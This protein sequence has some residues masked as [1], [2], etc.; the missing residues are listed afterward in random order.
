MKNS[1]SAGITGNALN[2]YA[3]ASELKSDGFRENNNTNRTNI[4]INS[5]Y[6]VS[7]RSNVQ[8]L[9]RVTKMKAFIPSSL[10][11]TTFLQTP[12][13]AA[14]NWQNI[15]GFENYT[16]GQFGLSYNHFTKSDEKISIATFGSF[17]NAEELRPFNLLEESSNFM[18]WRGYIQKVVETQNTRIA[19]TSGLEF[20]R[21]K[22]N[23][24]TLSNINTQLLSDN[25]EKRQY[26]NLFFQMESNFQETYYV[27]VGLNGNLTRFYYSDRF[28]ENGD[29]S[30][31]HSYKPVFSP[32][33]GMNIVLSRKF[34]IYG[35]VSH[36]F[37]TPTFEETLLPQGEINTG[38]KPESGLNTEV[39]F[40]SS[41]WGKIQFSTSYYRIY[42]KNLLVARRTGEDAYIGVNA[43]SSI[44]PGLETELKWRITSPFY[45]PSVSILGNATVSN[46]HFTD[47]VDLGVNYSGNNLPG[48]S[49]LTGLGMLNL[50]PSK[51]FD[52]IFWYRYT[53]EMPVNDAN[54]DFSESFGITNAEIN[55]R[56]K[57]NKFKFEVK[58]G[59]QNLFD[60]NYAG[61]LAVNAPSFG[62]G[63]PRYYY[64]G[65]PRNYYVTVLIGLE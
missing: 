3:L 34:S 8:L 7:E 45:Y 19:F 48:T 23:W 62:G 15:K 43:G 25:V 50:S 54:S 10:D 39:G 17:R 1:L 20:F 26:E 22:Y 6:T 11:K 58:A 47:F 32:R 16:N 33:L 56:G 37:S 18:G 4:L 21:E 51:N 14:S 46:Y 63:L 52:L 30:G 35:N 49:K 12:K 36:G 40:R 65:N 2:V 53:G 55:Y 28:L 13:K 57:S 9:L 31:Q 60:I 24:S 42:I 38:I 59:I 61:M 29:Q 5:F 41:L 27:S 44:H 64:P